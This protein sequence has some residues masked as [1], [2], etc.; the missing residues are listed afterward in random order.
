MF[1]LKETFFCK[2]LSAGNHLSSRI[3]MLNLG[4]LFPYTV[5]VFLLLPV[6]ILP[7]H[8][9]AGLKT[10]NVL[11]ADSD[12]MTIQVK[13]PAE[14]V[15]E[16][17]TQMIL[18]INKQDNPKWYP[19]DGKDYDQD[20]A[21]YEASYAG[22]NY[23]IVIEPSS[24][25]QEHEISIDD[26][27]MGTRYLFK[28]WFKYNDNG[29]KY[30][31][32]NVQFAS[33]EFYRHQEVLNT[34][35]GE[36]TKLSM[37]LKEKQELPESSFTQTLLQN[38]ADDATETFEHGVTEGIKNYVLR[39]VLNKAGLGALKKFSDVNQQKMQKLYD[40]AKDGYDQGLDYAKV[41]QKVDAGLKEDNPAL[42]LSKAAV[43]TVAPYAA[44]IFYATEL[45]VESYETT[46]GIQAEIEV[47][48]QSTENMQEHLDAEIQDLL[49]LAKSET[50]YGFCVTDLGGVLGQDLSLKVKDMPYVVSEDLIV[51]STPFDEY[52]DDDNTVTLSM[53]WTETP[54]I[55][56]LETGKD[57]IVQG[58]GAFD[59]QSGIFD[60]KD[61]TNWGAIV[62]EQGALGRFEMSDV[63][64]G[65]RDQEAQLII[66][67]NGSG[68][69]GF[70]LYT[71]VYAGES[72]GVLIDGAKVYADV[73]VGARSN[74][75]PG[76]W[77]KDPAEGTFIKR[78]ICKYNEQGIRFQGQE[79][80]KNAEI[81]T[82]VGTK[83]VE[84][85]HPGTPLGSEDL[86]FMDMDY[87]QAMGSFIQNM[88]FL[89]PIQ[90]VL[91]SG[92][93]TDLDGQS[94]RQFTIPAGTSL[95]L[96]NQTVQTVR[97]NDSLRVEGELTLSSNL[98][99]LADS[100]NVPG[101]IDVADQGLLQ[102]KQVT[103]TCL[104]TERNWDGIRFQESASSGT[105]DNATFSRGGAGA[106]GA[107]LSIEGP[108]T[109][110]NCLFTHSEGIGVKVDQ[111]AGT[112]PVLKRNKIEFAR[113]YGLYTY[114]APAAFKPR[115][116]YFAASNGDQKYYAAV[117]ASGPG[118]S[119]LDAELNFWEDVKGP[120]SVDNPGGMGALAGALVDFDPWIGK[121]KEDDD[122]PWNGTAPK[123]DHQWQVDLSN[124]G[125]L[126]RPQRHSKGLVKSVI[127]LEFEEV[128]LEN[129]E[130]GS[131]EVTEKLLVCASKKH[132]P[133]VKLSDEYPYTM[134]CDGGV[135][136]VYSYGHPNP[137]AGEKIWLTR[138]VSRLEHDTDKDEGFVHFDYGIIDR[139][140]YISPGFSGEDYHY[141]ASGSPFIGPEQ[142]SSGN[143]EPGSIILMPYPMQLA[144]D[145]L[146]NAKG[147]AFISV[148][149]P[150]LNQDGKTDKWDYEAYLE[151][152][153]SL[154]DIQPQGNNAGFKM[155]DNSSLSLQNC[156]I[157][158]QNGTG[159]IKNAEDS[160]DEPGN[161]TIKD[162]T[163]YN[164]SP[165]TVDGS[166]NISGNVFD[167]QE[168]GRIKLGVTDYHNDSPVV[169]SNNKINFSKIKSDDES[170]MKYFAGSIDIRGGTGKIEIT[171]NI[172]K[173]GYKLGVHL[174]GNPESPSSQ[175]VIIQDNEFYNSWK[176]LV[177]E[178]EYGDEIMFKADDYFNI[179]R[180][181]IARNQVHINPKS[182]DFCGYE[183]LEPGTC[184]ACDETG[185]IRRPGLTIKN[186]KAVDT[187]LDM[188]AEDNNFGGR[189][190]F[191]GYFS[192]GELTIT[193]DLLEN[194]SGKKRRLVIN[195]D[196]Y[197]DFLFEISSNATLKLQGT[198]DKP[199]TLISLQ[200]PYLGL[201]E[202]RHLDVKGALEASHVLFIPRQDYPHPCSDSYTMYRANG[203]HFYSGSSGNLQHVT[204]RN[205]EQALMIE[206]DDVVVSESI[207][208]GNKN[209][210]YI[211]NVSP[212][213]QNN[214]FARNCVGISLGPAEESSEAFKANPVLQG[215]IF[216]ANGLGLYA[217]SL[218]GN[219]A[220]GTDTVF[221][222][223]HTE[224]GIEVAG[225]TGSLQ[226]T[227]IFWGDNSGPSTSANT[228][229]TGVLFKILPG[230]CNISHGRQ[231]IACIRSPPL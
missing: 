229:G 114:N 116:N 39:Q 165:D 146:L 172:V 205:L 41:V 86:V 140:W 164:F 135:K 179:N 206:S 170:Q 154:S 44:P 75:G 104:D 216:E 167:M 189:V 163:L 102:A 98:A 4:R 150:D 24:T 32:S 198:E 200:P 18:V 78:A 58:G 57:I 77:L 27:E 37:Y 162:C 202:Y 113:K 121:D 33:D 106:L 59:V 45:A 23:I 214:H 185:H 94:I 21:E 123:F 99:V 79:T 85:Q 169:F 201:G 105:L 222:G 1:C 46:A 231:R 119:K 183:C 100:E 194:L 230:L 71:D 156:L 22:E 74:Q 173:E 28:P 212:T 209:A 84:N 92:Q 70:E 132:Y 220:L 151:S 223:D 69:N 36:L 204:M 31:S 82:S 177:I 181:K 199:L 83:I 171:D 125:Y 90:G 51:N 17:V 196:Q 81:K 174:R 5:L 143:I 67:S 124:G 68:E 14:N 217:G 166:V 153:D 188:L 101:F 25:G 42:E 147:A 80:L 48:T 130:D 155:G 127:P 97:Y 115:D 182:S 203:L 184:P 218:A 54:I 139:G 176:G 187:G 26:L 208:V 228:N 16:G 126:L 159:E 8:A 178:T 110:Q 11:E 225:G 61:E 73:Q 38:A 2:C 103:F 136:V 47:L 50:Y 213:L 148:N 168:N 96:D 40:A 226:A 219:L 129:Y 7:K 211:Y 112:V 122:D 133:G 175:R 210:T 120:V 141:P 9:A 195:P 191:S 117:Q 227:D 145:S 62:Y 158:N 193:S 190:N 53:P 6:L 138:A 56:L 144:D 87:S 89:K 34:I 88:D 118:S 15:G 65:G 66:R 207:F 20:I 149:I 180:L 186:F 30:V 108:V 157:I 107:Q 10:A 19:E 43:T 131:L 111:P 221:I 224:T 109:V 142:I 29:I 55:V 72:G 192:Q 128:G 35:S 161:L 12:S 215:N 76:L 60:K 152:L 93:E 137:A 49:E 3:S 197:G 64:H 52:S 134:V 13:A 160:D 63:Y 95:T 91:L